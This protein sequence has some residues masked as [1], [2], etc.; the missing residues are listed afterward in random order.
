[1]KDPDKRKK[2]FNF[3]SIL[4][5]ALIPI[6]LYLIHYQN[7]LPKS[8]ILQ[9]LGPSFVPIALLVGM[10]VTAI[11]LF[12][13]SLEMERKASAAASAQLENERKTSAKQK[14]VMVMLLLGLLVYAAI[15]TPL[16]FIISTTLCILYQAQLFEKG[17]WLRNLTVSIPFSFLVYYIFVYRLE[18][19]LPAG[20]L[21]ILAP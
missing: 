17:K 12:F 3:D 6:A 18:I 5:L 20:I 10:I 21:E 15:L 19:T 16:G 9:A 14:K 11:F 1:M 8:A 13:S 4:A 7:S 2:V